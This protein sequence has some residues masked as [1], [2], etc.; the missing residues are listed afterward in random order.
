MKSCHDCAVEIP[1]PLRGRVPIRC[2][3]CAALRRKKLT[4]DRNTKFYSENREREK[5]RAQD[6]RFRNKERIR[7]TSEAWQ[8]ANKDRLSGTK[9][10]WREKNKERVKQYSKHHHLLNKES[11]NAR[12]RAYKEAHKEELARK[13][14]EYNRNHPEGNRFRRSLR[15]AAE[16][17]ATPA[18]ADKEKMRAIYAEAVRLTRETGIPHHVDHHYPLQSEWCCG[19]H[20]EANL[21]I[22]TAVENQRKKNRLPEPLAA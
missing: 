19:L 13:Q 4:K 2:R 9:R 16:K 11:N 12:S 17:R 1:K 10:A 3:K 22:M 14:A 15:R 5:A 7:A 8:K 6:W 21:K 20:C 18:W